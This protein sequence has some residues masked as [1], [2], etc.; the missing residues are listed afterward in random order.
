MN[1]DHTAAPVF[2]EENENVGIVNDGLQVT[3]NAPINPVN[4]LLNNSLYGKYSDRRNIDGYSEIR[5]D[6]YVSQS[7]SDSV[8][9]KGNVGRLTGYY[10]HGKQAS[11]TSNKDKKVVL[12]L[13]GSHSPS[14]MQSIEIADYYREQGIDTLAVNMRGFGG[15]DG[16]PSEKGL[17]ADAL[18]MFRYLVNDKKID[19]KNIIIHGYSLG[20]PIAAS[21]ARDLAVKYNI[22][23]S[24][25]LLDRPMPSLTKAIAA[26]RNTKDPTGVIKLVSKK[27][28]GAFSVKDNLQ[29][30]P[31]NVP[32]MMLTDNEDLGDQGEKLRAKL[33]VN[34]FDVSGEK[35]EFGHEASA[36]VMKKHIH[37]II[38]DLAS[39]KTKEE[40]EKVLKGYKTQISRYETAL[41][42]LKGPNGRKISIRENADFL[43]GYAQGNA[44][45][46][47]EGYMP[48][49][50]IKSLIDTFVKEGTSNKQKGALAWE[51]EHRVMKRNLHYSEKFINLVRQVEPVNYVDVQHS[52][53]F[54]FAS[55]VNDG[56]GGRRD[57]LS[58]M[59]LVAK[60]LESAGKSNVA[61]EFLEKLYAAASII[62]SDNHPE[63]YSKAE[64]DNAK[65]LLEFIGEAH[66]Y[67][68]LQQTSIKAWKT[69]FS[70]DEGTTVSDVINK[71]TNTFVDDQPILMELNTPNHALSVWAKGSGISRV[72]GLYAPNF[73]SVEF[74]S[75]DKFSTFFK[76]FINKSDMNMSE[77]YQ[78]KKNKNGKPSFDNV[79]IIDG[80]ALAGYKPG[81]GQKFSMEE[82]VSKSVFE[83][84]NIKIQNK[85]IDTWEKVNILSGKESTNTNSYKQIIIE[86]ENDVAVSNS[87]KDLAQKY[88]K[89]SVVVQLD[90]EGKYRI[91]Y[92]EN[93]NLSGDVRWKVVG[94]SRNN[95]TGET[96]GGHSTEKLA[97]IIAK[98]K[99][100]FGGTVAD[101]NGV[102]NI[103]LVSA[104]Q[105][106][107]KHFN[108]F[109]R[110]LKSKFNDNGIVSDVTAKISGDSVDIFGRKTAINLDGKTELEKVPGIFS[111]NLSEL[112]ATSGNQSILNQLSAIGHYIETLKSKSGALDIE[113]YMVTK[114]LLSSLGEYSETLQGKDLKY[115]KGVIDSVDSFISKTWGDGGDLSQLKAYISIILKDAETTSILSSIENYAKD[116]K[117]NA[118]LEIALYTIDKI[119]ETSSSI[120]LSKLEKSLISTVEKELYAKSIKSMSELPKFDLVENLKHVK[121]LIDP[122]LF[123][124]IVDDIDNAIV[125]MKRDNDLSKRFTLITAL[126]SIESEIDLDLFSGSLDVIKVLVR[127]QS[128]SIKNQLR[129]YPSDL[130]DFNKTVNE[131]LNGL[132]SKGPNDL[133]VIKDIMNCLVVLE[134]NFLLGDKN[135]I[136]SFKNT[137]ESLDKLKGLSGLSDINLLKINAIID[138]VSVLSSK[139]QKEIFVSSQA[140]DISTFKNTHDEQIIIAFGNT[141]NLTE[142]IDVMYEKY[143]RKITVIYYDFELDKL[144]YP[145]EYEV[146]N[147]KVQAKAARP[148]KWPDG[149]FKNAQ[150]TLLSDQG[151]PNTLSQLGAAKVADIIRSGIGKGVSSVKVVN[152]NNNSSFWEGILTHLGSELSA[153]LKITE[154]SQIVKKD[155]LGNIVVGIISKEGKI[156]WH[157][158]DSSYTQET[159]TSKG[160]KVTSVKEELS[161]LNVVVVKENNISDLSREDRVI[162]SRQLVNKFISNSLEGILDPNDDADVKKFSDLFQTMV[163]GDIGIQ[164][165]IMNDL[166][167]QLQSV[168]ENK[169]KAI[170]EVINSIQRNVITPL[171]YQANIVFVMGPTLEELEKKY[172][173]NSKEYKEEKIIWDDVASDYKK[174]SFNTVVIHLPFDANGR[175]TGDF[176]VIG[177]KENI[178][179]LV[180][181]IRW[182]IQAHGLPDSLYEHTPKE[183]SVALKS[184][185]DKFSRKYS[186]SIPGGNLPTP[187]R[188]SA[189]SC[190]GGLFGEE[191]LK[192]LRVQGINTEVSGRTSVVRSGIVNFRGSFDVSNY[193]GENPSV[194]AMEFYKEL[195]LSIESAIKQGRKVSEIID[196][197]TCL[198]LLSDDKIIYSFDEK[199]VV[200]TSADYKKF[201]Q[202]EQIVRNLSR[203]I[204]LLKDKGLGQEVRAAFINGVNELAKRGRYN[205]NHDLYLSVLSILSVKNSTKKKYVTRAHRASTGT[206]KNKTLTDL[207]Q[208]QSFIADVVSGS[209]TT[210]YDIN[211]VMSWQSLDV[212][213]VSKS[214]NPPLEAPRV[215]VMLDNSTTSRQSALNIL[216]RLNGKGV[217]IGID[218]KGVY[219]RLYGDMSSLPENV[220]WTILGSGSDKGG[221]LSGQTATELANKALSAVGYFGDLY[222][223]NMRPRH[224]EVI[225]GAGADFRKTDVFAKGLHGALEGKGLTPEVTVRSGNVSTP[226][227]RDP[228]NQLLADISGDKVTVSRGDKNQ[229]L[230]SFSSQ[231][232]LDADI[233]IDGKPATL[234][235]IRSLVS[236]PVG[237]LSR[238]TFDKNGLVTLFTCG[239]PFEGLNTVVRLIKAKV[240]SVGGNASAIFHSS[241]TVSFAVDFAKSVVQK[242]D[243]A[244]TSSLVTS[245]TLEATLGQLVETK[246]LSHRVRK[247]EKDLGISLGSVNSSAD[248]EK[249]LSRASGVTADD[250]AKLAAR[251]PKLS[252]LERLEKASVQKSLDALDGNAAMQEV[253]KTA[254]WKQSDAMRYLR[255]KGLLSESKMRVNAE[256]FGRFL[257][258]G[259]EYDITIFSNVVQK[260]KPNLARQFSDVMQQSSDTF[261]KKQGQSLSQFIDQAQVNKAR[262]GGKKLGVSSTAFRTF[263]TLNATHSLVGGWNEMSDL[264]KGLSLTELVGGETANLISDTLFTVKRMGRGGSIAASGVLDLV[265][266]PV[267]FGGIALQWD[268]FWATNGD[269]GSYQYKSLVASTVIATVSLATS[270]ALTASAMFAATAL[271]ATT[272][273]A[274]LGAIAAVGASAGPIGL[275]IAAATFIIAGVV[276]GSLII[277]EFNDYYQGTGEKVEQFFA[278]W[279]GIT[280][281][282]TKEAASRKE[283]EKKAEDMETTLV[284]QW[285][286]TKTYLEAL[287]EKS[288]FEQLN[289]RDRS[290][291]V[292]YGVVKSNGDYVPILQRAST[293]YA[294]GVTTKNLSPEH[295]TES[296]LWTEMGK[297]SDAIIRGVDGKRNLF[298]LKGGTELASVEGKQKSD[299]FY[300]DSNT[301]VSTVDGKAGTDTL[302][303]NASDRVIDINLN[304]ASGQASVGQSTDDNYQNIAIRNIENITVHDAKGGV[305]KG[306]GKDNMFDITTQN[307]HTVKVL[308]GKGANV[309][310]MNNGI[311][312]HSTSN[313]L[314]LWKKA[315]GSIIYLERE[316]AQGVTDGNTAVP[317][318]TLSPQV[319]Q[320][321]L[322]FDYTALALE[323]HGRDLKLLGPNRGFIVVKE[324]FDDKGM[325]DPR[326]ILAFKDADNETFYVN[327]GNG[328]TGGDTFP[329]T[330]G[331]L[332]KSFVFSS[333]GSKS[334]TTYLHGDMGISSYRIKAGSGSFIVDPHTPRHMSIVLDFAVSD[335]AYQYQGHSLILTYTSADGSVAK[336]ELTNYHSNKSQ[337]LVMAKS[338]AGNSPHA[339]LELPDH[340]SGSLNAKTHI[341]AVDKDAR[342]R[343][344]AKFMA[345][346]VSSKERIDISSNSAKEKY[347]V[348]AKDLSSIAITVSKNENLCWIRKGDDLIVLDKAIWDVKRGYDKTAHLLVKGYFTHATEQS[349]VVNGQA[350]T[351]SDVVSGLDAYVGSKK[352]DVIHS[353]AQRQAGGEGRD[354]YQLDMNRAQT[355]IIEN[356]AN[357]G[358]CDTLVL[359]GVSNSKQVKISAL[360]KHLYIKANKATIRIDRY[361]EAAK[362]RHLTFSVGGHE[363]LLP[364]FDKNEKREIYTVSDTSAKVGIAPIAGKN[365][366]LI[367]ISSMKQNGKM[368]LSLDGTE[369]NYH[370][371]VTGYDLKL[372]HKGT[373]RSFYL[374]DYYWQPERVEV[375]FSIQ[376]IKTNLL[377]DVDVSPKVKTYLDAGVNKKDIMKFINLGIAPEGVASVNDFFKYDMHIR[378]LWL[379]IDKV[380]SE[381]AF[382]VVQAVSKTEW[383]MVDLIGQYNGKTGSGIRLY[384]S[385]RF[386]LKL[387][388]KT[389]SGQKQEMFLGSLS[390]SRLGHMNVMVSFDP[391][392]G[393]LS[394]SAIGKDTRLGPGTHID[395]VAETVNIRIPELVDAFRDAKKEGKSIGIDKGNKVLDGYLPREFLLEYQRIQQSGRSEN[396]IYSHQQVS[397]IIQL[398]G[399]KGVNAELADSLSHQPFLQQSHHLA[400]VVRYMKLGL[401]LGDEL[402]NLAKAVTSKKLDSETLKKLDPSII[403]GGYVKKLLSL[404]ASNT[405][406]IS[407]L[408]AGL[409]FQTA[410]QY[411]LVGVS[412]EEIL[413]VKAVVEK[414]GNG[415]A[416]ATALK[417]FS[418]L[419]YHKDIA[420]SIAHI[421]VNM[422]LHDHNAVYGYLRIGVTS[423]NQILRFVKEGVSPSDIVNGN[424]NHEGYR[425]GGR[426]DRI[427][428]KASGAFGN[429]TERYR[430]FTRTGKDNGRIK[431]GDIIPTHEAKVLAERGNILR[432]RL[433]DVMEWKGRAQTGNM[434]DGS[435]KKNEATSWASDIQNTLKYGKSTNDFSSNNFVVDL[436]QGRSLQ[437]IRFD[438]S[439]NASELINDGGLYPEYFTHY[440]LTAKVKVYASLDGETWAAVSSTINLSTNNASGHFVK[441]PLKSNGVA[442]RYYKLGIEEVRL[443]AKTIVDYTNVSY[444]TRTITKSKI[445]KIYKV[446]KAEFVANFDKNATI[447]FGLEDKL[448]LNTI[449]LKT[450][451]RTNGSIKLKFQAMNNAGQ[452][453]DV[454][455]DYTLNALGGEK[456]WRFKL[457][458]HGIPYK[459]YRLVGVS[460][461]LPEG[462]WFK[463]VDFGTSPIT[464]SKKTSIELRDGSFEESWGSE[465]KAAKISDAW[466]TRGDVS[467]R[468]RDDTEQSAGQYFRMQQD[469]VLK[470]GLK[471]SD[472]EQYCELVGEATLSR[473][474]DDALKEHAGY[475]VSL[476]IAALG[477]TLPEFTIEIWLGDTLIEKID[478]TE[479]HSRQY[480]LGDSKFHTLEGYIRAAKFGPNAGKL[481]L[482]LVNQ[483]AGTVLAVDNMRLTE[484]T[485]SEA[486]MESGR[487]TVDGKTNLSL[488]RGRDKKIAGKT[489]GSEH[490]QRYIGDF[491]G[492]GVKDVLTLS[493]KGWHTLQSFWGADYDATVVGGKA[494]GAAQPL[495]LSNRADAVADL[496]GDGLDDL[497]FIGD[498]GMEVLYGKAFENGDV[499]FRLKTYTR[500]FGFDNRFIDRSHHHK[501][502][503]GDLDGDGS[504]EMIVVRD[505]GVSVCQIRTDVTGEFGRRDYVAF[506]TEVGYGAASKVLLSDLD[507][508]GKSEVIGLKRVG[509][510]TVMEAGIYKGPGYLTPYL[511]KLGQGWDNLDISGHGLAFADLTGNGLQ[512]VILYNRHDGSVK[513]SY[514]YQRIQGSGIAYDSL[515][516]TQW[517]LPAGQRIASVRI[518]DNGEVSISVVAGDG[519]GSHHKY[520]RLA[521]PII[522]DND[523]RMVYGDFN[524]DGIRNIIAVV[525]GD[526]RMYTEDG[527]PVG[528]P[529]LGMMNSL[530]KA[531]SLT[532]DSKLRELVERLAEGSTKNMYLRIQACP[533]LVADIN[534][535]GTDDL[536]TF[537]DR[538]VRHQ[539]GS[540]TNSTIF[541]LGSVGVYLGGKDGFKLSRSVNPLGMEAMVNGHHFLLAGETA[542]ESKLI[543]VVPG[544]G[545]YVGTFGNGG[546][547]LLGD[548]W[549]GGAEDFA[550]AIS[551]TVMTGK[552]GDP[553]LCGLVK[554]GGVTSLVVSSVDTGVVTA[555]PALLGSVWHDTDLTGFE[556]I[557]IDSVDGKGKDIVLYNK[558][559][560]ELKYAAGHDDATGKGQVFYGL[561]NLGKKLKLGMDL[562]DIQ[563]VSNNGE[564]IRLVVRDRKT[565]QTE[566]ETARREK[567]YLVQGSRV[568]GTAGNDVFVNRAAGTAEYIGGTGMDTYRLVNPKGDII[569]HNWQSSDVKV[570]VQDKMR[571]DPFR[572]DDLAFSQADVFIEREGK[573]YRSLI[574][575]KDGKVVAKVIG[576]M[577][578]ERSR[579]LTLID[580]YGGELDLKRVYDA[581]Q[582]APR[583][584]GYA[585]VN[586]VIGTGWDEKITVKDA[587]VT[588]LEGGGGEDYYIIQ[589]KLAS[590]V[591]YNEDEYQ[592]RDTI[593][594]DIDAFLPDLVFKRKRV[595]DRRSNVLRDSLV[596]EHEGRVCATVIGFM[597]GKMNQHLSVMITN[598]SGT[599]GT[600]YLDSEVVYA[601][602]L[603]HDVVR[604]TGEN[605]MV[606]Y[607]PGEKRKPVGSRLLAQAMSHMSAKGGEPLSADIEKTRVCPV[608]TV[609]VKPD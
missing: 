368:F 541:H 155:I 163:D 228:I 25:L 150:V 75:A 302:F 478:W 313:D 106:G 498:K 178:K 351:K 533:V 372:V 156:K 402:V 235:S 357:G 395:E 159:F 432:E 60:Y 81:I 566:N 445:D 502:M 242:I 108:A 143:G 454:S 555:Q 468:R 339:L 342:G 538:V 499:S 261:L 355:Y 121:E 217:V 471:A 503:V 279:I 490:A 350:Y 305:V 17:Y 398:V 264:E 230:T 127:L 590:V 447:E 393:E 488:S 124:N 71:V 107:A 358:E 450:E 308:G 569:V 324:F 301:V 407:S 435:D 485:G 434:V 449:E 410:L 304:S 587:G 443:N 349:V 329:T 134:N 34:G 184:F 460:G 30:L 517:T 273:S 586:K 196:V 104:S 442:Y 77:F 116:S 97:E 516:T 153:N 2:P 3:E 601:A 66:K 370:L 202:Q 338:A 371:T 36:A 438:V 149:D 132:G 597:E 575:S 284:E 458:T 289:V 171:K 532:M 580:Q 583:V 227:N 187:K 473:T 177:G 322:P 105:V 260:I 220:D 576:F 564:E 168:P 510:K 53:Q 314:Y 160:G 137:L 561:R 61:R 203:A 487:V 352:E 446:E 32:I 386:D 430:Y 558:K 465:N 440:S 345:K 73:G 545:I 231:A 362:Y 572:L 373:G 147:G 562:V 96:F 421:M 222:G 321:H 296:V 520:R 319:A 119:R 489:T 130:T 300:L 551:I 600:G 276:Q 274:V 33:E 208:F 79:Y 379:P 484:M 376:G 157:P 521:V 439:M 68:A 548:R 224:V 605:T 519:G 87:V 247:V 4:R 251:Y 172:G 417:A 584:D 295:S 204:G 553:L 531:L 426:E 356:F 207:Q 557:F 123:P 588:Y 133:K 122:S 259:N 382:T 176:R 195:E 429:L 599:A 45:K 524:G 38:S 169:Q 474:L 397:A 297:K 423:P 482:S 98:F 152:T 483:R 560:G 383:Q 286:K 151:K 129:E 141:E 306:D 409:D 70:I 491:N 540:S 85:N 506:G 91:V 65:R 67:N 595:I 78:L 411:K 363:Y 463:E 317:S 400:L 277:D 57:P 537:T 113:K 298:D 525:D 31:S 405:F 267:T 323:K 249:I 466:T 236:D 389:K 216:Q 167:V 550:G 384:I 205:Q 603:E 23:V 530:K 495:Y 90:A 333:V 497:L 115:V 392:T 262:G 413:A 162:I 213:S 58:K 475:R 451:G 385:H 469:G 509:S 170:N 12:F 388:Y 138:V 241:E 476:D 158:Y 114:L 192:E 364:V 505:G 46:L 197:I 414:E 282:A 486:H 146:N 512:D 5:L 378:S 337:Y 190:F 186:S 578:Y 200:K 128:E 278:S 95:V 404:G 268:S 198:R 48:D 591:I 459:K 326:K 42:G 126:K 201:S 311:E 225:G 83:K 72:Y 145:T 344:D 403:D 164:L 360:G 416:I 394:V 374:K 380:H 80:K 346:Q 472:G 112:S 596:I 62:N 118:K 211:N 49:M 7:K 101:D 29:G 41:E 6:K 252:V 139:R 237:A 554:R 215:I 348:F 567:M 280:T 24:G 327:F 604:T 606:A 332:S 391:D 424:K 154:L 248:L 22:S 9:L 559:T 581:L 418:I 182:R 481:R 528:F 515:H 568:R 16:Q 229:L 174:R 316:V 542:S 377:P 343:L 457:N 448:V 427:T 607:V 415:G 37:N 50:S 464:L 19:P 461:K 20:A 470:A 40:R 10:H 513:V 546:R 8:T 573:S 256:E 359:L 263:T 574:V 539:V 94:H 312:V 534:G 165:E 285:G 51:I 293:K 353:N 233:Q 271:A 189:N 563:P 399:S 425:E 56:F 408:E 422:D 266:A 290:F 181:N 194:T 288:G 493:E 35:T 209:T 63:M 269:R 335:I 501:V 15:S 140:P 291:A 64:V 26:D 526:L 419:G 92:G 325:P 456:N 579:H 238:I 258:N 492:D 239:M 535:D 117:S 331:K 455:Q 275:A 303:I 125:A 570:L 315:G 43:S 240:D 556:M 44:D 387:E 309:Y 199:G 161:G 221:H 210:R 206:T 406:V 223:R 183:L 234:V 47:I 218:S 328:K 602:L 270:L 245:P 232:L 494:A 381:S 369:D 318:D 226:E 496:D 299:I 354:S 347:V 543:S 180:G 334:R 39:P 480:L 500:D 287:F 608:E 135:E 336:V 462:L 444:Q 18:T 565:G 173:I 294:E 340:G 593:S 452:W 366:V 11:E 254:S 504:Q 111:L 179:L 148:Y 320:I 507:G 86:L 102:Q 93:L 589:N 185:R 244:V 508:D 74:T 433:P 592:D 28:N 552:L 1:P 255:R 88:P 549:I 431:P 420:L 76:K 365:D 361:N 390:K 214:A 536:V 193:Y 14:E 441:F 479:A 609:M 52:P 310:A 265:L 527:E 219:R 307:G 253:V 54:F 272:S 571:L 55:M 27:M 453:R 136:S 375:Y 544:K 188:I 514:A 292:H 120:N 166:K 522:S 585:F 21:L 598:V 577:D 412:G 330:L 100:D 257:K 341:A 283:G 250:M 523:Y 367:D 109:A 246:V 401:P 110:E 281:D 511:V 82:M 529:S 191:F 175:A 103:T 437:S 142:A 428:V 59:V 477:E 84:D 518:Q 594:L 212:T 69:K 13:H 131:F 467:V 99:K 582:T 436:K 396:V 243:D 89:N 547:T 144:V